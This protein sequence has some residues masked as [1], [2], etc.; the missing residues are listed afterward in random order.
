[1]RITTC[2]ISWI[3]VS[4]FVHL[5]N[6]FRATGLKYSFYKRPMSAMFVYVF[7]N[8]WDFFSSVFVTFAIHY[9]PNENDEYEYLRI[10]TRCRQHL[11]LQL[12]I[13]LQF[14]RLWVSTTTTTKTQ[15]YFRN[16]IRI[17]KTKIE[18]T[19]QQQPENVEII[20]PPSSQKKHQVYRI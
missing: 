11:I 15:T 14:T 5:W 19:K 20:L 9:D 4:V 13:G 2:H 17:S 8:E 3:S 6:L 12:S 7:V 16:F 18:W 10:N 1:M